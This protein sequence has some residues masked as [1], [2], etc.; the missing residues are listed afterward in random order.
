MVD[1]HLTYTK[2]QIAKNLIALEDH[3][4]SYPCPICIGKHL[5][6]LEEYAEEGIPMSDEWRPLFNR[7]A[8][9]AR[10]KRMR[11]DWNMN[12]MV[13][14]ARELRE[15][16]QDTKHTHTQPNCVGPNCLVEVH[17]H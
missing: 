9:W 1:P 16:F 4:K 3:A 7:V 12:S 5:L 2:D 8:D 14:E 17:T 15:I 13:K 10:D 6:A 11:K